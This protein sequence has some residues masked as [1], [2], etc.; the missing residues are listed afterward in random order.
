MAGLV[1]WTDYGRA[2]LGSG[3][4]T[5]LVDLPVACCVLPVAVAAAEWP[6]AGWLA[7]DL[8]LVLTLAEDWC[9]PFG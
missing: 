5:G 3:V 2:E 8:A 4:N 7:V 6:V 1:S 9:V